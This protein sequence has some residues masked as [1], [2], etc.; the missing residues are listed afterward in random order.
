M[1]ASQGLLYAM[2]SNQYGK[3]GLDSKA[4]FVSTP[5]LVEALSSHKVAEVSCGLNHALCVM[6][7]SG[8][9]YSWGCGSQGQLGRPTNSSL[10]Q[11]I[12]AFVESGTRIKQVSAGGKHSLMLGEDGSVYSV[13]SNEFG[14]LGVERAEANV[15]NQVKV[16]KCTQVLCGLVHSQA[17]SSGGQVFTFGDNQ[18]G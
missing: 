11:P 15:I 13:G 7:D 18:F 1:L 16:V 5:K 3:L 8:L 4:S 2:G 14:Q 17:L 9:V 10:P 6:H 12:L